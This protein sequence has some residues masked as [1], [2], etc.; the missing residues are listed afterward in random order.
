M[1]SQGPLYC[2]TATDDSSVGTVS[3]SSPSNIVSHG[4]FDFS[5]ANV[6]GGKYGV[7]KIVKG[8]SLVGTDKSTGAY[9]EN[10][11]TSPYGIS[12]PTH[13]FG[14]SSDLWGTTWSYSDI[15]DSG[16]GFAFNAIE[17]D[18]SPT[19]HYLKGT[20]YGFSIPSGSTI[21]GIVVET[22]CGGSGDTYQSACNYI[23]ITVYYTE[24]GGSANTGFFGLM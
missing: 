13:T 6:E 5:Y 21:D 17:W 8:G 7:C 9:F 12:S 14:S 22:R 4:A 16:F 15:N 11:G 20:N 18:G 23:R 24:G 19:T 10:Y 2:G 3:W 1:A